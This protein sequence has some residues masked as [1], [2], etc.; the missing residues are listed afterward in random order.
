MSPKAPSIFISYSWDDGKDYAQRVA[1]AVQESGRLSQV[2]IDDANSN[3]DTIR[4]W[5]D[6]AIRHSDAALIICSPSYFQKVE[7]RPNGHP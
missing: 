1:A 5:M 4:S 7:A 3:K 6:H 2:F